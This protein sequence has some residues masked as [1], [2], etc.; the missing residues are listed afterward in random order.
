MLAFEKKKIMKQHKYILLLLAV[1]FSYS[2]KKTLEQAPKGT[3]SIENLNNIAGAEAMVVSAYALMDH[4]RSDAG[5]PGGGGT[6]NPVSNWSY[7]DVRSDDAYKGGGGTGDISDLNSLELGVVQPTN[8][9]INNK[10]R[11]LFYGVSRCNKAL[12]ILNQLTDNG[13]PLR[14]R[15]IAEVKVLR[16]IYYFDLKKHF[17]TYPYVDETIE[18][19]QEGTVPNDKTEQQLWD[20]IKVDFN[21]GTT[22]PFDGQDVGRVN[23][24]VAFAYLAKWDVFNKKWAEA[25][26]NADE[27]INS[28][29]YKLLT[30]LQD[31]YSDPTKDHAG[32]NIF[33]VETSVRNGGTNGGN[34]NWGEQLTTP[35]GPAYGGGDGFHR[36]TQNLVNAFKVDAA[37]GL[38]LLDNFNNSDFAADDI[39]TP[40][41]PRLDHAIGRPGIPWKDYTGGV[42]GSNWIREGTT[43]GLFSTK[44]NIVLV[45]SPLRGPQANPW[46]GSAYNW[47]L[48]K[49]SEVLLWKAEAII[50]SGGDLE[51]AKGLVNQ[52]RNRAK[53]SP[54]VTKLNSTQP[55]ANYKIEPYPGI[56]VWDQATAKKALRFERRLEL[57]LEGIRFYDLVRWGEAATVINNFYATEK[58]KRPYLS[59]GSYTPTK[60][61]YL[62]IP[63]NEID[64]SRGTYKQDPNY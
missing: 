14:T 54:V 4:T 9:L 13:Y 35:P 22:I 27:V 18:L 61:D 59:A 45:N 24:Y 51:Q 16:G 26:M 5:G 34:F 48:I 25:I 39:T 52:I 36:P 50:E 46:A 32:E 17:R 2:C 30:N 11:V 6:N 38:P 53:N 7:G 63:Q 29:K 60:H 47:P 57:C 56:P 44:K 15:R 43:Y 12:Q 21:A 1:A 23:K 8:G 49:Y 37:T 64:I 19:G 20:K 3:L 31:L 41:D 58:I 62:P 42:Y 28:G 40:V 33:A 10:W 55:A